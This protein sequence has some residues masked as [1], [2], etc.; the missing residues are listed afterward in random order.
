MG[1]IEDIYGDLETDV[2]EEEFR[3][4]VEEKVEQMGGLADEETAAM[5]LAHELNEGEVETVADIE[6]GM[7]EVKFIAKVMAVGEL[8]TFE[9]DGEDEDGR[10]INV[11]AADET[12]SVRLAFWDGQ[13]VDIDEGGLEVGDV[14]RVKG[15]PQ[16]GYNGLEVSVDKAEPDEDA[17]VDV[18]PGEGAT[19]A[20]LTMGQSD[21]NLRGLVLDTD[22][23]RTFDRDDG[24]EG[25]VSNLLLGD[26]TGRIRVTMWD[27]QADRAEEIDPGAAV[28]VVD[29]YVRERDGSLELHVGEDGAVDEVEDSVAFEPDADPIESVEIDE[30][31]DIAGV[32]RSTDPVRTFDRDDGS[33]G[34][35]RNIRI[36]DA[37]GDIRV[38]LWGDKADKEIAPG[39]EVLAA[40]VEIQDGWQDDKEA[41]ANWASSVVVLDDAA[42]V[43]TTPADDAGDDEHAG[44]SSFGSGDG[45]ESDASADGEASAEGAAPG[46]GSNGETAGG[47]VQAA[48]QVEFTGTVVQTGDP[49][50]LDDGEETMSVET[51]E[52]VQLGQEITVR[53]LL[54]DGRLDADDVF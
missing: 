8:R 4:A 38:A 10:V 24:S 3:E 17:T 7:D 37:T 20:S 25:R 23:V 54:D 29:G 13:A 19:A 26:E 28:E 21:V 53:G 18:E 49:V 32:V 16:D 36:Q 2:S 42:S 5:L 27:D 39:D 45:G 51:S 35:V 43:G 46:N 12:A 22:A 41:S 52:H 9:R 1:A 50:V 48:E 34:Q 47:G 14:L 33:E 31:V 15:R 30:T 44:L 6:P 11:D 40:D